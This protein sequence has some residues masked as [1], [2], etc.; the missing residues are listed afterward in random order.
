MPYSFLPPS[1]PPSLVQNSSPEETT[2]ASS[3]ADADS[4]AAL[5]A[6]IPQEAALPG[7]ALPSASLLGPPLSTSGVEPAKAEDA[8]AFSTSDAH[9]PV[10]ALGAASY[11]H[12]SPLVAALQ[13]A[14]LSA[15]P[16]SAAVQPPEAQPSLPPP[17]RQFLGEVGNAL[18]DS[19]LTT[20]VRLSRSPS[21]SGQTNLELTAQSNPPE[22]PELGEPLELRADRQEYNDQTQ[23]FTAAG[24]V[25]LRFRAAELR[26]DQLRA[27]LPER[28]AIA[29]GNVTLT[30]G[31]QV[32]RGD[33]LT[34]NFAQERG[35]FLQA[36]GSIF[37]PAAERDFSLTARPGDFQPLRDQFQDNQP[38]AVRA[39][40]G[41]IQRLRFQAARIDFGPQ[42]W[43]AQQIRIT[44]D[45]FS[46]PELEVRADRA[47]LRRISRFEDRVETT[48]PRLVLDQAVSLPILK[49]EVTLSR[50]EADPAIAELGYDESDRGGLFV[51]RN[52]ELISSDRNTLTITPQF[53]VQRAIQE[54][55]FNLIDPDLYGVKAEFASRLGSKTAASGFA[56]LTSIDPTD[57]SDNLRLE[58]QLQRQLGAQR[59]ALG[60]AYRD[61]VFNG[62]LGE[63]TIQSRLGVTVSPLSE[64]PLG[65]TG[66]DLT[67]EA[68]ADYI[69]ARTDRPELDSP[70]SLGRLR[71]SA[72]VR[73][74][75]ILWQGQPLPP[76]ASAGLRYTAEP[77]VPYL[78]LVPGIQGISSNYSNGDSQQTLVG[79]LG[80]RGQ[81]GHFSR[82]YLDYTG[83]NISY[84]Q[85]GQLGSSPFLFDRIVDFKTLSAGI[86]QQVYGP[87]RIGAQTS[88]NLDTGEPFNT[89]LI[90]DYSRR[91]YGLTIRY[92][93]TE[94]TGSVSFRVNGFNW[95][96]SPD[97]FPEAAAP[98]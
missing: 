10:Y 73:R 13:P 72:E 91:T 1:P 36:Q 3:P 80:L 52:V 2:L 68:S 53:F 8:P 67:Y 94:E 61:R 25:V 75:F 82:P 90:L 12:H 98:P 45:P 74:P 88:L 89:V 51:G 30:R 77:V 22:T 23:V 9:R 42:G 46:P 49:S 7:A 96:S 5:A 21:L 47:T 16:S 14:A 71:A 83:F 37:L 62:S 20:A 38:G 65:E 84:S 6:S 57:L 24:N 76:T 66:I 35:S 34:Y 79:T 69:T 33:Q 17:V 19:G 41:E 4:G 92:S 39:T 31:Q 60:Y 64:I 26:A 55:N 78:Q 63:Q 97:S 59:L 86:L 50:R 81:F 93:P 54:A 87:I 95:E 56:T 27:S 48:R 15:G 32:L 11:D 18:V 70:A 85:I 43:T 44:N 40:G 28:T 29:S 58:T